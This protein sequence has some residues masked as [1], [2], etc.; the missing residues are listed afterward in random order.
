MVLC[1]QGLC[2]ACFE[3]HILGVCEKSVCILAGGLCF[4]VAR[5]GS[6]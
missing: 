1:T 4:A 3:M 5:C 6:N 2:V